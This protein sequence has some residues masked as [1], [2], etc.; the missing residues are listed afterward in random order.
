MSLA[1]S[2]HHRRGVGGASIAYHLALL[3]VSDVLLSSAIS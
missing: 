3:G 2:R 1:P